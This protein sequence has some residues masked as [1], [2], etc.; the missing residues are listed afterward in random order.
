VKILEQKATPPKDI[1]LETEEVT[2]S[3]AAELLNKYGG[4]K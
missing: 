4:A 1:I 2:H 3:N